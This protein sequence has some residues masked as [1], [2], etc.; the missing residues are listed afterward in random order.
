M[1][2]TQINK[3]NK[4][5]EQYNE[6]IA[7]TEKNMAS[8]NFNNNNNLNNNFSNKKKSKSEK[9]IRKN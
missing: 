5:K 7:L 3:L 1:I 9:K 2:K 4:I 8:T 6:L